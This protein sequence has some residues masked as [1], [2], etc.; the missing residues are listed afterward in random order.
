MQ[1]STHTIGRIEP[2]FQPTA[3]TELME[4]TMFF[5]SVISVFAIANT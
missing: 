1:P 5:F 2:E 4:T 3:S